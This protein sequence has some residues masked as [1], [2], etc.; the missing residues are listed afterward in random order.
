MVSIEMPPDCPLNK[1]AFYT[2]GSRWRQGIRETTDFPDVGSRFGRVAIRR[3][4]DVFV[5]ASH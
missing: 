5:A 1:I 2:I 4:A 3:F